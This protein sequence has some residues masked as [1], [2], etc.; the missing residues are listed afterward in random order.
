MFRLPA[1]HPLFRWPGGR[2]AGRTTVPYTVADTVSAAE[3]DDQVVRRVRRDGASSRVLTLVWLEPAIDANVDMPDGWAGSAAAGLTAS[4][5][6]RPVVA[7][8][9]AITAIV[10]RRNGRRRP[11]VWFSDNRS[12]LS[13]FCDVV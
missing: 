4:A 5:A 13:C 7:I 11:R 1:A 3:C 8:A 10:A 12:P 6:V 2:R 9:T